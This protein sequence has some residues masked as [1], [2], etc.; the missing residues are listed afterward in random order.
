ML[1]LG[2]QHTSQRPTKQTAGPS[3]EKYGNSSDATND[4]SLITL[5]GRCLYIAQDI[6]KNKSGCPF[7]CPPGPSFVFGV[8][9]PGGVLVARLL[10]A[11]APPRNSGVRDPALI[12][13]PDTSTRIPGQRRKLN[14][15]S[16]DRFERGMLVSTATCCA[17][18]KGCCINAVFVV[19]VHQTYGI[20][21]QDCGAFQWQ[22]NC[23]EQ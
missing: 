11:A 12:A 5:S 23:F 15:N 22:Q 1:N 6:H 10:A 7:T 18:V 19:H 17:S 9:L 20:P 21:A 14:R 4:S 2:S 8:A 16:S 13:P 3:V